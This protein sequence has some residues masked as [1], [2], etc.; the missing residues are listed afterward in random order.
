MK[1]PA[2]FPAI[3][4]V[5]CKP[6]APFFFNFFRIKRVF[7]FSNQ[8]FTTYAF[9]PSL[10][11]IRAIIHFFD[12]FQS[13]RKICQNTGFSLTIFWHILHS[14][15]R[16]QLNNCEHWCWHFIIF[17]LKRSNNFWSQAKLTQ[18]FFFSGNSSRKSGNT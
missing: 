8:T 11:L 5:L 13:L 17:F 16:Q 14:G 10:D 15:I 9:N 6:N 7:H 18:H 12:A 2:M 4:I 3:I 1:T